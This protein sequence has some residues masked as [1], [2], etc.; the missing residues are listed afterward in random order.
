MIYDNNALG[1]L[2]GMES[3]DSGCPILGYMWG[4]GQIQAVD[5]IRVYRRLV[6]EKADVAKVRRVQRR[7]GWKRAVV[8]GVYNTLN[9]WFFHVTSTDANGCPKLFT[10]EA[11]TSLAPSKRDWFL[12][13]EVMIGL[14]RKNMKLA[15]VDVVAEPRRKGESKVGAGTVLEFCLNFFRQRM[16]S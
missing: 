16:G 4:D 8:S 5:V 13:D 14:A 2:A 11:W 6:A 3:L 7:D 1:T 12:D 10:R 15:E 9:L